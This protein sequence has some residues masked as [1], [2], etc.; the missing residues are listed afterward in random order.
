MAFVGVHLA[1]IV[2]DTFVPFGVADVLV[3]LASTWHPLWV[4][5]GVVAFYLLVAV[6]VT[7]LLRHRLPHQVWRGIHTLS[8]VLFG[9]ATAHV[10]L[11][12][13]DT[14]DGWALWPV[15][16]VTMAVAFLS[17]A[18]AVAPDTDR[19]RMPPD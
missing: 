1:A 5:W 11:A 6:E 19:P 9:S 17:V 3:P 10:L 12:S 14:N 16:A 2:A 15:L 13:T 8:F 4:V 7:S 18:R